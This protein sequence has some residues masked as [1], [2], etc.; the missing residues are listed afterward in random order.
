MVTSGQ[1]TDGSHTIWSAI[2]ENPMLHANII[3]LC[4]IEAELLP[5]EVLHCG[6]SDFLLLW[7]WLWPDDLHICTWPVFL[8]RYTGCAK[9]KMN[10]LCQVF[11]SYRLT[12]FTDIRAMY[13]GRDTTEI[14]YHATLCMVNKRKPWVCLCTFGAVYIITKKKLSFCRL[15]IS[16]QW[17]VAHLSVVQRR[18]NQGA[19]YC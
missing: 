7:P 13:T 17:H 8:L 4:L 6:N 1:L 9:T 12:L 11:K 16:S 19:A 18:N 3:A 15:D 10:F 2:A 5:V 14:V